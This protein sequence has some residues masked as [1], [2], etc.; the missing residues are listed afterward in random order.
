MN[1]EQLE[2]LKKEREKAE[3]KLKEYVEQQF[4]TSYK[5][6]KEE[7]DNK[8]TNLS[9]STEG[10]EA[11][12]TQYEELMKETSAKLKE[13]FEAKLSTFGKREINLT[14][15]QGFVHNFDGHSDKGYGIYVDYST[16]GFRFG[17]FVDSKLLKNF[18]IDT[19]GITTVGADGRRHMPLAPFTEMFQQ[20]LFRSFCTVMNVSGNSSVALPEVENTNWAVEG[21]LS[22]SR[23]S[24]QDIS[25]KNLFTQTWVKEDYVTTTSL[26][27][28]PMLDDM[29]V[30][31]MMRRKY[32]T[33]GA[34]SIAKLKAAAAAASSD[35][36][37]IHTG[38]ED[39]LPAVGDVY[40]K[41]LDL[42][43]AITEAYSSNGVL[44]VSKALYVLLSKSTQTGGG[45]D[46][47]PVMRI[48]T[49]DGY[50]LFVNDYLETPVATNMNDASQLVAVFGDF[51]LGWVI[52]DAV[53]AS[54][55]RYEQTRPGAIT[56]FGRAK[57]V[58]GE[59]DGRALAV[60]R[61][62]NEANI[63]G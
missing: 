12:F 22:T 2:E 8:I 46:F 43:G 21:T 47:D 27:D 58:Q 39:A 23:T 51:S 57:W 52:L 48:R 16:K 55:S 53:G 60:L 30:T 32:A 13:E 1:L 31:N 59:W 17:N 34:D 28:T 26:E 15:P 49:L 50:P 9:K 19:Q 4:S 33:E 10:F 11:K 61:T 56:Y 6:I 63:G 24:S 40:G 44:M 62:T 35:I 5:K 42:I 3:S 38:V 29:V 14:K 25:S 37:T 45:L 20:N 7:L 18:A 41:L 54:I 36:E